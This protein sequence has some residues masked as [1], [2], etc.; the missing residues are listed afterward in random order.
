MQVDAILNI[1]RGSCIALCALAFAAGVVVGIR[2]QDVSRSGKRLTLVL[3]VLAVLLIGGTL[4]VA[5]RVGSVIT[6]VTTYLTCGLGAA[7]LGGFGAGRKRSK[8]LMSGVGLYMVVTVVVTGLALS[9]LFAQLNPISSIYKEYFAGKKYDPKADKSCTENLQ[10]LYFAFGKYVEYNDSLPPAENWQDQDDFKAA[11]QKDEWLHCPAVS[12]R[13]DNKFG[14]A[15]NAALSKR[16]LNGK[17]LKD[18][19]DAAKTPLLY[20]ST[21]LAKN[22]HDS[23]TS[24]PKPGRHGGKNNILFC[25]GHIESVPPK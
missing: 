14:Y 20:D 25:D 7:L 18:M 13:H 9:A 16:K 8:G 11:I 5:A 12:N 10:S 15:Y 24:L 22:A 2:T 23:L 6:M 3:A 21:D 17:T 4:P 19:P 1:V